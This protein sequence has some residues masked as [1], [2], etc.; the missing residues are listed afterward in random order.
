[1]L[2]VLFTVFP[3]P[4]STLI[5]QGESVSVILTQRASD[6][7]R[8]LDFPVFCIDSVNEAFVEDQ[9]EKYGLKTTDLFQKEVLSTLQRPFFFQLIVSGSL[10][11]SHATKPR[12]IFNTFLAHLTAD[13]QERFRTAFDVMIPLAALAHH[14]INR[15]EEAV[16]VATAVRVIQDQM[17]ASGIDGSSATDVVNWLVGKDF[18][19]PFSG[20]RI[21]FF[22]QSITE[23]LAATE[24]ARSY[25]DAPYLLRERLTLRRWDQAIFLTLSL[26]PREQATGFL[27]AII[28]MDLL[29]A[30]SAVKFMESGT[31]EIVERLLSEVQKRAAIH[32]HLNFQIAWTLESSVPVSLRHEPQL[33]ALLELGDS[34]GG[35]EASLLLSLRGVEVKDEILELLVENCE[36]YNFCAHIGGA[37]GMLILHTDVPQL[38]ALTDRVQKRYLNKEIE[39]W[40]GFDSALGTILSRFAPTAVYDAFYEPNK[41]LEEQKVR[42]SVLCDFLEKSRSQEALVVCGELTLAG[43]AE[44]AFCVHMILRF[45]KGRVN[46]DMSLFGEEH[47]RSLIALS[48]DKE[49]GGWAIEALRD[50]SM[51]RPDVTCFVR[52]FCANTTGV[53]HATLLSTIAIN[54]QRAVFDAL[55]SLCD[56]SQ[57]QLSEEPLELLSHMDLNWTGHEGLFVSLLRTR[58]TKFAWKLLENT[59]MRF[60]DILGILEIGPIQWWLE[61]IRDSAGTNDG[62]WFHNRLSFLFASKLSHETKHAFVSE[63]NDEHSPYRSLL[64]RTILLARSDLSIDNFSEEAISFLLADLSTKE[65]LHIPSGHLLGIAA[66]EAFV[67][68]RLLPL[69]PNAEEPLRSNLAIVLEQ[70]GRRHGRRYV[71][72]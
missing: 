44:A 67:I 16:P 64:A 1:M 54:D 31:E 39:K 5:Y 52:D 46:L 25:T 47:V 66:T 53:I 26:L 35:A 11:L 18:L 15:G 3:S 49:Y 17:V 42:L 33:R 14:A 41:P 21:A 59:F 8:N 32:S 45:S 51:T 58:H 69:L 29:L 24:L 2:K 20:G 60:H 38:V 30:L 63:F 10:A 7:L 55:N 71:A 50:I 57:E 34:V 19:L 37:L 9:I 22:H 70:A 6:E 28:E 72:S 12:D 4:S 56:F 27:E 43:V 23:Y 62:W 48:S 68:E 36:D 65:N 40:E 13:F 61:W